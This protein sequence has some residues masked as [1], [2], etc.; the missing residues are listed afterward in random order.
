MND[1]IHTELLEVVTATIMISEIEIAWN[2]STVIAF[3]QIRKQKRLGNNS[4]WTLEGEMDSGSRIQD[5]GGGVA[6]AK[7]YSA[8]N[9]E[10]VGDLGDFPNITPH[11]GVRFR[12]SC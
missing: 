12:I 7:P 3:S 6:T 8:R 2:S 1:Y 10:Q 9:V 11:H 5:I 4:P